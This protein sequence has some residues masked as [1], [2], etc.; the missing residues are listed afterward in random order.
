MAV[1]TYSIPVVSDGSLKVIRHEPAPPPVYGWRCLHNGE[2]GLEND[3]PEPEV[4][5]S[6]NALPVRFTREL[7]NLAM[8][9]NAFN[10]AYDGQKYRSTYHGG[11]AFCNRNGYDDPRSGPRADWVN[12]RDLTADLPRLMKGIIC[13]GMFIRGIVEG[14]NLVCYPGIH[15]IDANKPTPPVAEVQ[16]KNWYFHATIWN[17]STINNFPQGSG[18]PVIVPYVL[19]EPTPYPLAWFAPWKA[20]SLPDPLMI[21]L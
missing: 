10:P 11:I 19:R 14:K 2:G 18:Q 4:R 16:E 12:M 9:L 21:Y 8:A 13:G 1:L 3:R 7:Q 17:G 6:V 15:A 20:E 5:P